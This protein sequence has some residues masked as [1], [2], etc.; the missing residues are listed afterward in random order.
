MTLIWRRCNN[1]MLGLTCRYYT[2][3]K[4][5]ARKSMK[6]IGTNKI[7]VFFNLVQFS[8]VSGVRE[9]INNSL[10]ISRLSACCPSLQSYRDDINASFI[11]C[12]QN[13][14]I[15]FEK[16]L[17][18]GAN[19]TDQNSPSCEILNFSDLIVEICQ[20]PKTLIWLVWTKD[21]KSD[22]ASKHKI[23]FFFII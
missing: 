14:W 20:F 2:V 21:R 4:S 3:A 15:F 11:N 12:N 6:K 18:I 9:W 17:M 10:L 22:V 16:S 7:S 1:H 23:T 5:V 19:E 8:Q 13:N